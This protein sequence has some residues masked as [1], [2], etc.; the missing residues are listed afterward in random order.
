MIHGAKGKGAKDQVCSGCPFCTPFRPDQ[1]AGRFAERIESETGKLSDIAAHVSGSAIEVAS[2]GETFGFAVNTFTTGNEKLIGSLQRIETA[3]DKSMVR[4]DEQ[5]AYYVAQAREIIDL[6]TLSQKE[7]CERC[8]Q[9]EIIGP[10][11]FNGYLRKLSQ[12]TRNA[13]SGVH[14]EL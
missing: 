2:L 13:P 9:V 5:L 7:I 8:R 4:S 3:L 10:G 12:Q 11:S 1:T 14:L 6:S